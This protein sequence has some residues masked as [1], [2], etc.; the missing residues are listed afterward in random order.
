MADIWNR[1]HYVVQFMLKTPN[2]AALCSLRFQ[3]CDF[4]KIVQLVRYLVSFVDY[5]FVSIFLTTDYCTK[6]LFAIYGYVDFRA[7]E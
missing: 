2:K 1:S 6:M 3:F 5:I 4:T 7:F